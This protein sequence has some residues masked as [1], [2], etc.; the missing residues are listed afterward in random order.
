[1][2][3]RMET[4]EIIKLYTKKHLSSIEIS[5]L[6]DYSARHIRRILNKKGINTAKKGNFDTSCTTCGK[7]YEVTRKR[8]RKSRTHYC[9]TI[10]RIKVMENND[11]IRSHKGM[12]RARSKLIKLGLLKKGQ[13]IH[14][15]DGNDLNNSINNLMVFSN[16]SEHM[17]H[18]WQIR[19]ANV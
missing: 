15:K 19:L 2:N 6:C 3:D 13:C 17:K 9:S 5:K 12:T 7:L 11:S 4:K 1:M 8:Y 14:H 10:C 18:H 16:H